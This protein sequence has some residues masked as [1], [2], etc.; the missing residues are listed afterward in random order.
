MRRFKAIISYDGTE[1]LGFQRQVDSQRTVQGEIERAF[2][3]IQLGR[4]TVIGAGRTDTAVHATGQVISFDCQ[5]PHSV[6]AL[7]SALNSQLPADIVVLQVEQALPSFHARYDARRRTYEYRINNGRFPSV[8]DR[9]QEWHV[10]KPLDDAQMQ[11]AAQRLIGIHNFATFGR[12]PKGIN[13]VREVYEARWS[14]SNERLT[15]LITANAFL[16]R[17]VRSIVGSLKLV[18]EGKWTVEE[19]ESALLAGDRHRCGKLAPP[20]GLCLVSVAYE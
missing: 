4:V 2:S 8:L 16:Y 17:M 12:P 5:W 14:R 20:Q 10:V 1:F 19:F 11:Q 3:A 6:E 15:F 7:Q 18:G 9:N 13:T